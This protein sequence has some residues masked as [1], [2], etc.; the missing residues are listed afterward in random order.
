MDTSLIKRDIESLVTL[1]VQI[2]DAARSGN[3]HLLEESVSRRNVLIADIEEHTKPG[4]PLTDHSRQQLIE[5]IAMVQSLD[6]E[7]HDLV[8][9]QHTKTLKDMR[10]LDTTKKQILAESAVDEKGQRLQTHG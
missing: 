1:T 9:L 6:K 5:A 2:L 7:I 3:P 10:F 8:A 4:L